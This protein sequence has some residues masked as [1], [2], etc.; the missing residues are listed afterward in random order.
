MQ[1]T[2]LA[3]ILMSVFAPA[4]AGLVTLFLPRDRTT[5]RTLIALVGLALPVAALLYFAQT[6]GVGAIEPA[7]L[8]LPFVPSLNLDLAF[9][10]DP[11]GMFFAIL[12]AGV[13][14]LIVL[15]ARA[16]FGDDPDSLFR[17]YPTLGFFATAMLG[18]VLADNM[19]AM[20]LFWELTSVSSFLLIGWERNDRRAVRLAFQALAVTGMGGLALLGG[21]IL[22]ALATGEWSF[23]AAIPALVGPAE[24]LPAANLVPWAFALMFLG[25]ATKSAQWP[26]HFWLPGAMAAP[27]PV[28]A[29][30]HSATMV[31][32]GV[33]LFG[34]LSPAFLGVEFWAATLIPIG[35]LTMI[36]GAYLAL[37]STELKKIFAYT[38]VSQLGL[39][40]CMFGLGAYTH[41]DE[42]NLVWPVTQILNHALYK[43]PLFLMAGAIAHAVHVKSL[44]GLRGFAR[45][46]PLLAWITLAA[47]YGLAAGPFTLS[48]AAK[49][50]FLYQIYHAIEHEPLLWIVAGMAVLTAVCNVAIFVRFLTTFLARPDAA[51]TAEHHH[52]HEHG[53]VHDGWSVWLW[54]PALFIVAWQFVGGVAPSLIER[55]VLPVETHAL[56]WSHL[57]TVLDAIAHPSIPLAMSGVAVMLGVL[58]GI[59]PILRRP[60]ADPHDSIFPASVSFLSRTGW[61]VFSSIQTGNLRH[62]IY[63]TLT[64]FLLGIVAAALK[65]PAFLEWPELISLWSAPV[66]FI[67]ASICLVAL[68]IAASLSLPIINSR[69]VRVLMLGAVG[70][71]VTGIYLIYEAPDLALTQ[72]LFEI[73]SIML[74]LLVLR[75]IPEEPPLAPVTGRI[76]RAAFSMIVG[77]AIGWT[78]LQA[79]AHADSSAG[80]GKLGEWFL[81]HSYHGSEATNGRGGGGDNVVNVIL[82]DF[83]GYDTLGEATVLAIAGIGIFSLIAAVPRRR[84]DRAHAVNPDWL[85]STLLRTSMRLILPLGLLFA[86]YL[87][88]KGHNEPGGGFIA[89]LVA[90]VVLATYRMA[91]GPEA[92]KRLLPIKPGALAATGLMIALATA[93]VPILFGLP[94]LTSRNGYIPLAGADPFHFSTV[95]FFDIGVLIVVIAVSVGVINRLTE[96][97][98]T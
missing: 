67:I 28:S 2:P 24:A 9:N 47:A 95:V 97:L 48:F 50:A 64:A 22:L 59:L 93:V 62:Y 94:V 86:A 25:G 52:D 4:I 19:L 91:K 92:L 33:Y 43:A 78:V 3:L 44:T 37:R 82:V 14:T 81:A 71:S 80:P 89:G 98:E 42:P 17:F 53:Q 7:S 39:F 30:L 51:H 79:G 83:R 75:M 35:A 66:G 31:K 12:V 73:I 60:V 1:L 8:T 88:F 68:V 58:V 13:G 74:F 69:I 16:Y 65:D 45:T 56:Y 21:I 90:S 34:R 32:A 54:L 11:L 76:G 84:R 27:T 46:N 41:H 20:L 29:Y 70:M 96:E 15:Y 57:P 36:L 55:I 77:L 38:T 61:G 49:E 87:F 63:F 18:V 26:F 10:P 5:P 6:L 72:L 85:T 23:S 40:T